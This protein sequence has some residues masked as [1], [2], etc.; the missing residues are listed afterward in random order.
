MTWDYLAGISAAMLA[1]YTAGIPAVFVAILL[2]YKRRIGDPLVLDKI[3][4]FFVCYKPEYFWFELAIIARRL[5]LAVF[6]SVIPHTSLARPTLIVVCFLA[7]LALQYWMWPFKRLRDNV[8]EVLAL[9]AITI[10]FVAQTTWWDRASLLHPAV[11][12]YSQVLAFGV[13]NGKSMWATPT[14]PSC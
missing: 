12:Y 10:T 2:Y 13:G 11:G 7:A 5:V 6:I 4:F 8:L 1:V 14:T 3:G 9:L